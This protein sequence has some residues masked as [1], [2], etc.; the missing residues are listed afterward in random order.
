MECYRIYEACEA[1]SIPIV[2][3]WKSEPG[4]KS[5]LNSLEPFK[6]SGA[7]FIYIKDWAT[8]PDLISELIR[9]PEELMMRQIKLMEWYRAFTTRT[10]T[11]FENTLSSLW[12]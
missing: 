3:D 6:V 10:I 12:D 9:D 2:E 8:L 4:E 5:C 7:P 11:D 1:G